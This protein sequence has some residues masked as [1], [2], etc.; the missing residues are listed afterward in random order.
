MQEYGF[1]C[2]CDVSALAVS[3]DSPYTG[4]M[5]LLDMTF[6]TTELKMGM[7]KITST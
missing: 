4:C 2:H 5:I 7:H 1:G 6:S 3:L